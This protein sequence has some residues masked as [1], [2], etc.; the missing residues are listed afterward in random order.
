[1]NEIDDEFHLVIKCTYFLQKHSQFICN[2][3][4]SIDTE[5]QKILVDLN[6]TMSFN[7]L[8]GMD[9]PLCIEDLTK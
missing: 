8:M 4:A 6:D 2:V 3:N 5:S 7:L 9:Y 1:M